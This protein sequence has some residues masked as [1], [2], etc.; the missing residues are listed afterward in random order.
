MKI[1]EIFIL[2]N[3]KKIF[4]KQSENYF[5]LDKKNDLL[6]FLIQKVVR[7]NFKKIYLLCSIKN[8]FFKSAPEKILSIV[9]LTLGFRCIG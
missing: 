5:L 7:H 6:D 3:D 9:S 2:V 4:I 1:N 8:K